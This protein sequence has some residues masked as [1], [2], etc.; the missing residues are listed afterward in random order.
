M[1]EVVATERHGKVLLITLNR[2]P[3]NAINRPT[4]R[5][6]HEALSTLQND[7]GLS[8]GVITGGGRLFSA[9]WD[10]K[11][12]AAAEN[13]D[14]ESSGTAPGGFGGISEYWDLHKPVVAAVNGHA[15]GGGFEI[16]LACDIILA[17]EATEFWLP[18]M[19][20]GFLPDAGAIQRL[21]RRIPYN[22]FTEMMLTGRH[23]SAQEAHRWGLVNEVL[24]AEK[25]LPRAMEMATK[26]AESAPLALQAFKATMQEIMTLSVRE[27][28]GRTKTGRSQIPAYER[29]MQSEDA[30]EG[31]RAFAAKRKPNWKGR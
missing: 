10:L 16:A 5:A 19:Q 9:G 28:M 21:P 8:V 7:P 25:V 17:N 1:S 12:V 2:P 23:L 4:S 6:L 29:M 24:P 18:E 15:I 30:L 26:I 31:P 3:V 27:A 11:A 22:I 13:L 20:L 14:A